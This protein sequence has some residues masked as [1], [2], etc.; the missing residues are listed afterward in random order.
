[1]SLPFLIEGLPQVPTADVT[2]TG[3]LTTLAL[4]PLPNSRL[5]LDYTRLQKK[6]IAFGAK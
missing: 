5:I 2:A 1:L 4:L 6:T 3:F